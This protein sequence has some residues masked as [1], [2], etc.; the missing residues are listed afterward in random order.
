MR[1]VI[2]GAGMGGLTLAQAMRNWADVTVVER[3]PA[4]EATGGYR[5]HLDHRA[6]DVLDRVLDP[7]LMSS[8]RAASDSGHSFRQ[9]TIA[10]HRLDPI[11]VSR[12][13]PNQ[14]R[15]LCH[16]VSL[17]V[18]LT[19]GLGGRIQFGAQVDRVV[20]DGQSPRVHLTDGVTLQADIVV[21][22]EGGLSPTVAALAGHETARPTGLHGIAGIA[23]QVDVASLPGYLR[24][25]PTLAVSPRGTGLFLSLTGQPAGLVWGVICRR[26]QLPANLATNGDDLT[27]VAASLLRDWHPG[28]VEAIRSTGP[29]VAAY[30][31]R[32]ANHRADLTPWPSGLV[33]AIGDAVHAM[34]PTGGQAAAT[35]IRDAGDLADRLRGA[36][37]GGP[38]AWRAAI[39][40]YER[41]LPSRA[42]PALR[43]SLGPT[44]AIRA[45]G[46]PVLS[47]LA[48]PLLHVAGMAGRARYGSR[49]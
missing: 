17:R 6:C 24:A 38:Q 37:S 15:L 42:V 26:D 31:F 4:P 8:I 3:D 11:L 1:V 12:Q 7:G 34:P 27:D 40:G 13:D 35:A 28:V 45:L 47:R 21:G 39:A 10:N 22:A 9:F 48:V 14:D 23:A 33:T 2:C 36:R 46:N 32:A 5:L 25:G 29:G 41:D 16:R 30:P 44:R 43:E 49:Q 19:S 20:L 18:L